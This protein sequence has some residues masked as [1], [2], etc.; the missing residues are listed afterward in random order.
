MSRHGA[1]TVEAAKRQYET[2]WRG[3]PM[4]ACEHTCVLDITMITFITRFSRGQRTE[5]Q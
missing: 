2:C 3:P 1:T 5:A 4:V